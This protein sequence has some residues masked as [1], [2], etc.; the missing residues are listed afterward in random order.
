MGHSSRVL[1][2]LSAL[3]LLA[4]CSVAIPITR[5][6][7]SEA[8]FSDPSAEKATLRVVDGREGEETKFHVLLAGLSKAKVTLKGIDSP[9]AFLAENL[10]KEFAAR[11]YPVTV[12]TDHGV[13]ADLELLVTRYRI[14][15][16]RVNG[17]TPWEA[18][19]EFRGV[20]SSGPRQQTIRA[21]F[22]NGKVP[23]WSMK[24]IVEPCFDVPQSL[25]VKEIA[26][27]INHARLGFQSSD[28]VVAALVKR[29]EPKRDEN[30]GPFW[31]LTE[32]GGTNNPKAM[33]SLKRYAAHKDEFV[34]ACAL[35][36]IGMLGPER[37][38]E[39]LKERYAALKSMDKYMALKAIGD[40][41]DEA[42][43]QFVKSQASD[44]LYGKESGMQYL[45]D[46]Y[47][48]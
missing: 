27:K 31:E 35:S 18:M 13:A 44:P 21:Y 40:I 8:S 6:T 48:K 4:G 33:A 12:T 28:E 24:D 3:V 26:S 32:L 30:D 45:V 41:G 38:A 39:F 43:L 11:G 29:A 10:G 14:V 2:V 5:P 1:G 23:V 7:P 47:G 9:I 42:S 37:E 19:H 16:R 22:F 46:L 25:V 15:S 17:Y 20:L 34:R 36:A